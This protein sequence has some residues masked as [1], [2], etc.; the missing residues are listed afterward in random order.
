MKP[1]APVCA[2]LMGCLMFTSLFFRSAQVDPIALAYYRYARIIEDLAVEC[3]LIFLSDA[4][5]EDRERE[6]LN[7]KSNFQ[8]NG[9]I[10]IARRTDRT[11]GAG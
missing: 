6:L 4:G 5:G 11:L 1:S 8:P 3:E 2:L 9:V 7:F 10:E